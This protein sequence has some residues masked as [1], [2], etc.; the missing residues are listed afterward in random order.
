MKTKKY[1]EEMIINLLYALGA[2]SWGFLLG[3]LLAQIL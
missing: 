2:V 1:Y 3:T